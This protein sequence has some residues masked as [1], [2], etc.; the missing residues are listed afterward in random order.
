MSCIFKAWLF[1]VFELF[2][3]LILTIA[4]CL[5]YLHQGTE[6]WCHGFNRWRRGIV[7]HHVYVFV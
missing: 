3:F 5:V 2:M 6:L 1:L 4:F 7:L